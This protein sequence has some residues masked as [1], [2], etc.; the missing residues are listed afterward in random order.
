MQSVGGLAWLGDWNLLVP[1]VAD[2]VR[3]LELI[4]FHW[5][6]AAAT[7][8]LQNASDARRNPLAL[9]FVS[10]LGVVLRIQ[11]IMQH[12]TRRPTQNRVHS[13]PVSS[14]FHT[15]PSFLNEQNMF[16]CEQTSKSLCPSSLHC[17]ITSVSCKQGSHCVTVEMSWTN[18][19][20]LSMASK[21][22]S[23]LL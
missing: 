16:G 22:F 13:C 18:F 6:S 21:L 5:M 3:F 9:I 2:H 8:S 11:T 1:V 7:A 17:W 19:P 14:S 15:R 4:A 23:G 12:Y 20:T 10:V